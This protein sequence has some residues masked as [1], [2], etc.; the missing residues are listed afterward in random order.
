MTYDD[1]SSPY[2]ADVAEGLRMA[3][4]MA[5]FALFQKVSVGADNLDADIF[6]DVIGHP[7]DH[8]CVLVEVRATRARIVPAL[9][10]ASANL[11]IVE[12][13]RHAGWEDLGP[14]ARN[15]PDLVIQQTTWHASASVVE[16]VTAA[17]E[18]KAERSRQRDEEAALFNRAGIDGRAHSDPLLGRCVTITL[19]D[20]AR[21]IARAEAVE[22]MPAAIGLAAAKESRP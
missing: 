21:L 1:E 7:F 6:V 8:R 5:S 14:V 13:M 3:L 20:F 22:A 16:R 4:R 9:R 12:A 11:E 17:E 19:E 2:L 15:H 10:L 18:A